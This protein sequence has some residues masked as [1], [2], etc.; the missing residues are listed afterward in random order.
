MTAPPANGEFSTNTK[1]PLTI[2]LVDDH[3]LLLDGLAKALS[4]TQQICTVEAYQDPAKLI[5]DLKGGHR[6][7]LVVTDMLLGDSNGL[8][9]AAEVQ[10]QFQT[11]VLLMTGVDAPPSQS[12]L[13]R[14]NIRGFVHKT[15]PVEVLQDAIISV[16]SG[17]SYLSFP[18]GWD[19]EENLPKFGRQP[20]QKAESA[21]DVPLSQ[22][23]IEVLRLVA[24]GAA[25]KEIAS[26][27]DITE[28]TVK[29]HMKHLFNALGV[30]KR[31]ACVQAAKSRG[32]LD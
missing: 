22:R 25:N 18:D 11:S 13:A 8:T 31:T 2:A 3:R 9:L 30:T 19:P 17:K 21:G 24:E 16:S 5:E 12:E 4:E 27:L 20:T 15:A 28:N 14:H 23:Q 29:T 6:F 1:K 26:T 32:L 10:R 7:D